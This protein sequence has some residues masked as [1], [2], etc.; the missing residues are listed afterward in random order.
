MLQQDNFVSLV[1]KIILL[2]LP[3]LLSA[4]LF[5]ILLM[6]STLQLINGISRDLQKFLKYFNG[7]VTVAFF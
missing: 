6:N 1:L 3:L 5:L 2:E 7:T 4:S